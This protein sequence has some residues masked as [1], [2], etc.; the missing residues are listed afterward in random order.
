[1]L[2]TPIRRALENL[3]RGGRASRGAQQSHRTGQ[4]G[5]EMTPLGESETLPSHL[6]ANLLG[7]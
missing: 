3:A 5:N 4:A 2:L 1:M 7:V 6:P